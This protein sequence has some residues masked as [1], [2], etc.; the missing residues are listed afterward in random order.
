MTANW[1]RRAE[2]RWRELVSRQRQAEVPTRPTERYG[3]W[4]W[5]RPLS[6]GWARTMGCDPDASSPRG[7][8]V[9]V[10][11]H[12]GQPVG[13]VEPASTMSPSGRRSS[14]ATPAGR[15]A[16]SASPATTRSPSTPPRSTPS[17]TLRAAHRDRDPKALPAGAWQHP[18]PHRP[19]V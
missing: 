7:R 10:L 2:E 1:S 11:L 18:N 6:D 13:W 9:H 14:T 19:R 8:P 12:H 15:T 3:P 4:E 17:P 5:E 16:S